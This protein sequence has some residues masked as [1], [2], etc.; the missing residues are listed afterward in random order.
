MTVKFLRFSNLNIA[1][2]IVTSISNLQKSLNN[3]KRFFMMMVITFMAW[4]TT[5]TEAVDF[6]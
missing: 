6:M 5:V 4:L 2:K 3:M 1:I